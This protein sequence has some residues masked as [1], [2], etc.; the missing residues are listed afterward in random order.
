MCKYCK[1]DMEGEAISDQYGV[2]AIE[3]IV[4]EGCMYNYC[5]CGR[6]SIVQIKYC[7]MCG[8]KLN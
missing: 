6:H 7:P 5:D 4:T 8:R 2:I 1:D 3:T